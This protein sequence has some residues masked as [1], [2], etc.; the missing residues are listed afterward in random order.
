MHGRQCD[1]LPPSLLAQ[2]EASQVRRSSDVIVR[3]NGPA[4]PFPVPLKV[5]DETISVPK[6]ADKKPKLEHEEE[7]GALKRLSAHY[8]T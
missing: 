7:L 1:P 4:Y 8:A 2:R 6:S 3:R 5:Y